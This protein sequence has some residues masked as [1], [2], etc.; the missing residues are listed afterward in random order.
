MAILD[1]AKHVLWM[2]RM[3]CTIL[4]TPIEPANI[5]TDVK[6]FNDNNGVIFLSQEAAI[7]HRSKHIDIH[8]HFIQELVKSHQIDTTE[9]PADMLTKNARAN[10]INRCQILINNV[11]QTKYNHRNAEQGRLS[12]P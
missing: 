6:I 11:S 1:A 10:I 3:I 5:I 4:H 8:Y 7:N 12:D 9:M 2:R